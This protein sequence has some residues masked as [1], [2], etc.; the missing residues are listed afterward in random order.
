MTGWLRRFL[1]EEEGALAIEFVIL[2]PFVFGLFL[3][4]FEL[5]TVLTQQVMLDRALDMAV[6]EVRLG[7]LGPVTHDA[8]KARI[9]RGAAIIPDCAG[10]IR[11]EMRPIDPRAWPMLPDTADCLDRGNAAAPV[12]TFTPGASNSL[13][14]LRA[15]VLVDPYFPTTG[16]GAALLRQGGGGFALVSTAAFVVEPS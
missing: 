4:T 14:L 1:A 16:L 5:G 9:C 7:R 11:L 6:R 13:M 2:F 12:R 8:L 15:C 10:Q 3:S